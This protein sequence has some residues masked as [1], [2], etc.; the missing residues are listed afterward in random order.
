MSYFHPIH[1]FPWFCHSLFY[2]NSVQ[3]DYYDSYYV[4]YRLVN[5]D[6]IHGLHDC[7]LM[8]E[9]GDLSCSSRV[10]PLV[11]DIRVSPTLRREV[12]LHSLLTTP[13]SSTIG[14]KGI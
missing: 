7:L 6:E 13:V 14:A 9:R 5:Y 4:S 8:N 10:H 12:T 11:S 3:R 2:E 1:S